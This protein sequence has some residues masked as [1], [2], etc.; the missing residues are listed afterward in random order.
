MDSTH[1]CAL[2]ALC[3]GSLLGSPAAL[4]DPLD[5]ESKFSYGGFG[6][7]GLAHNSTAGAEFIRD[8][9][10]PRGVAHGWS[11]DVDS[12][13]GLQASFRP[14]REIETIVQAV[15]L[16]N[17]KGSYRPELTWAFISYSPDPGLST[18]IGRLGWDVYMLSD[19]RNVGYSYL[20]VRP[21]VDYFGPLQ[22]AHL[23]GAD[24]TF[25]RTLGGGLASA[26]LYAGRVRQR[27]PT[28]DGSEFDI[29]GSKVAGATVDYRRGDWFLRLG[30]SRVDLDS[31]FPGL[32][33]LLSA[34]RG[35][36]TPQSAALASD[37]AFDGKSIRNLIAGVA[38]EHESWQAQLS[39]NRKDSGAL[40]LRRTDSAY[41]LLGRRIGEWTG[42]G[43]LA[44]TWSPASRAS[45]G[46]PTPN[47]LDDA[48][49]AIL[50]GT[51]S[52][53]RSL[54]LGARYDFARNVDLKLQVDRVHV[55]HDATFLWRN[56]RTDWDGRATVVSIALDF[57]F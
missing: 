30:Y 53:Q 45:T 4:A 51:R 40:A 42:F 5:P 24:A 38:W 48:A 46:L 35:I 33:P 36:G 7:V 47:P 14:T 18:R 17:D 52:D 54:S 34:L 43:T 16:Y 50:A 28:P 20:W 11:A 21:P 12:R 56:P 13:L 32:V 29:S 2:L 22:I 39:Y 8:I 3:L 26:K 57:V 55:L 1:S 19:S 25:K 27:L 15:S 41:F 6:T 49:G 23:D 31:E 10:Q 44:A 9:L 37:L